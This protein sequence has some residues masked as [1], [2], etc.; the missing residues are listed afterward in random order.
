[1]SKAGLLPSGKSF[2]RADI[3][4]DD[5]EVNGNALYCYCFIF[6]DVFY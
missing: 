4:M 5:L 3:D 6:V 1:M 2:L